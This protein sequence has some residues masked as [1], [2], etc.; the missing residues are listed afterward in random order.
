MTLPLRHARRLKPTWDVLKTVSLAAV[1]REAEA[2]LLAVVVGSPQCRTEL[3]SELFPEGVPAGTPGI[4]LDDTLSVP[5]PSG[6]NFV[7]DA[8]GAPPAEFEGVRVYRVEEIGDIATTLE[9]V[10]DDQPHL[11]LALARHFPAYRQIVCD[12]I[13]RDTANAN[14]EFA[15]INALPSLAPLLGL[16]IPTAAV[17]DMLMLAKNQ[18]FML[19]RLAAAHGLPLDMKS[20]SRDL[21]PLLGNA[22]GWRAVAREVVGFVPGGVGLVARGAIAY[23]GTMALG[24]A[25]DRAYRRRTP[26]S[27]ADIR[28]YYA[29]SARVSKTAVKQIAA[30]L[31]LLSRALGD[32]KTRQSVEF[33]IERTEAPPEAEAK[34]EP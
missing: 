22:F 14:A 21:A 8:G 18:A 13:I 15:M 3:L 33:R 9:R 30:R 19:Y 11:A 4:L 27:S 16:L 24:R 34:T 20:R 6:I 32:T 10:L 29:E 17:S 5:P 26:V 23:S 2:P 28:R 7:L 25:L 12:R 31:P 1:R